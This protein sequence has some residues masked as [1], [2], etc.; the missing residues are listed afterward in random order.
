MSLNYEAFNREWYYARDLAEEA[1]DNEIAQPIV[2]AICFLALMNRDGSHELEE[3]LT[4]A[5]RDI[6]TEHMRTNA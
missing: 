3:A 2:R 4:L 5:A 6:V 1:T